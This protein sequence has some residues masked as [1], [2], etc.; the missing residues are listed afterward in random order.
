MKVGVP[1]VSYL[2]D[3]DV[4]EQRAVATYCSYMCQI[5]GKFEVDEKS[6]AMAGASVSFPIEIHPLP[7]LP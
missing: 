2:R 7:R 6:S 3:M 1:P 4:G 5:N